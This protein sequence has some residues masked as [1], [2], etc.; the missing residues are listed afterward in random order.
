MNTLM[1]NLLLFALAGLIGSSG[2][3]EPT[4]EAPA[5]EHDF[6]WNLS[7][8]ELAKNNPELNS[9]RR[10]LAAAER[11]ILAARSG[12][13]P[14]LAAKLDWVKGDTVT[15][16]TT[17]ALATDPGLTG[18]ATTAALSLSQNI[19][20]GFADKAKVESAEANRQIAWV[21]LQAAKARVLL[22]LK[23]AY[24]N[25]LFAILML[26]LSETIVQRRTEN[27]NMVALSYEGGRE[28]R[29]SLLLSKINVDQAKFERMQAENT[30]ILA[31]DQFNKVIGRMI[32]TPVRLV[33]EIPSEAPSAKPPPF[34]QLLG[35]TTEVLLIE[36]QEEAAHVALK[37][38]RSGFFP[39]LDLSASVF[40][41][42]ADWQGQTN[43]WSADFS[44]TWPL[45]SGGKDYYG[46]Q[47]AAESL[48]AAQLNH[49]MT[50]FQ[51][52]VRLRQTWQAWVEAVEL[53]KVQQGFVTAA[54]IR[55][56]IGRQKYH[57]SLLT[58]DQWYDIENDRINRQKDK[59]N[60]LKNKWLTEAAWKQ[61][62]GLS[63][64]VLDEA[65]K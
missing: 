3:G 27:L 63:D 8:Q 1:K 36:A 26:E 25:F 55:A 48:R 11:Q 15:L 4:P 12:F 62:L 6:D 61:A 16:P 37:Q 58:F 10:A 38:S 20:A 44:L 34:E 7:L 41:P 13:F 40:S 28:N 30:R 64:P 53:N 45:F 2:V 9:N 60:G 59:L 29:G 32:S 24:A 56:D 17:G 35:K 57:N 31:E 21:N 46:N 50:N 52:L 5:V 23:T 65:L 49:Q 18:Y 43:H 54:Q 51:I 19:F 14:Q 42:G 39:S 47:A 33:G 22:E